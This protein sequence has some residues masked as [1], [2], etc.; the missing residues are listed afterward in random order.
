MRH[1]RFR[2]LAGVI[3][4]HPEGRV[5]GRTR[6]QKTVRLLQ[7]LGMPTDY[8][9][10]HHF[11]GP[12]SEG[13]QADIGLLTKLGLITEQHRRATDGTEYYVFEA[14]EEASLD[15][16]ASFE[17]GIEEMSQAD[18]VVLE[19]AATYDAYRELGFNHREALTKLRE[20]KRTKVTDETETEA[21][22][23]L[24]R[25]GLAQ[26]VPRRGTEKSRK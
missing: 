22:S 14:P 23:L 5:F 12:Y 20:K 3:A 1:E 7:R 10:T 19:L 9:Y 25:L 18:P 6:L 15:A 2:W 21:L 13:L 26:D 16:I 4:A 8:E 11:Y 17:D 24:G